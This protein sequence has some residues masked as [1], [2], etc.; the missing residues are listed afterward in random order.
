MKAFRLYHPEGS[1]SEQIRF[2]ALRHQ[3]LVRVRSFYY[4]T[5]IN[6]LDFETIT[7]I[8]HRSNL[9][10]LALV[11]THLRAVR[12]EGIRLVELQNLVTH[13]KHFFA[14][15]KA[16]ITKEINEDT[17]LKDFWVRKT[18]KLIK[19]RYERGIIT[20]DERLEL[21]KESK[22]VRNSAAA[23]DWYEKL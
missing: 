8:I 14:R 9:D 18:K 23:K 21:L 15:S 7:D 5:L 12:I 16:L 10:E 3:N 11:D 6:K 19:F 22:F 1:E 4:R 17:L 20:D 13:K 2:L